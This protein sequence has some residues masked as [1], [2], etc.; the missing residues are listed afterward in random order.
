MRGCLLVQLGADKLRP[1]G[2]SQGRQG[3]A[4]GGLELG[5]RE[6]SHQPRHC[7]EGIL[8]AKGGPCL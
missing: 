7:H 6:L 2:L 3:F 4:G 1:H 5:V 8:L